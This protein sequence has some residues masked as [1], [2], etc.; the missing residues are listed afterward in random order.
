MAIQ[1][2]SAHRTI[3]L[4]SVIRGS[5]GSNRI[6]LPVSG[7]HALYARFKHV[8]GR[9]D[10][11]GGG[12]PVSKL[13]TLDNLIDRLSKMKSSEPRKLPT[14]KEVSGLS[15]KSIDAMI[16]DLSRQLHSAYIKADANPFLNLGSG[17]GLVAD[18]KL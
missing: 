10:P 3:P 8:S 4:T 6:S 12:F 2:I 7:P 14:K 17:T 5:L 11:S 15:D 18:L 9:I 1:S 16:Q 13:R